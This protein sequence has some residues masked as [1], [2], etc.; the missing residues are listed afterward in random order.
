MARASITHA[1]TRG[2]LR[3]IVTSVDEVNRAS[4][5]VLEKLGFERCGSRPGA[6]GPTLLLRLVGPQASAMTEIPI[7]C[8]LTERELAERRAGLLAELRQHRQEV[9]WLPDGAAFRYSSAA[10]VVDLL[11]EFVRLES[12]CCP[13]LRFRL[14]VEPAGGPLWLELTG[15]PDVRAFLEAQ[16]TADAG[17]RGGDASA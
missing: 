7:A 17:R 11:T 10:T 2:R 4:L 9:R 8:T 15:G 13:F 1:R 5:R 14:T 16:V 12:R 3:D 6:F